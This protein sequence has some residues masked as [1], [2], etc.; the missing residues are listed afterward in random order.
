MTFRATDQKEKL[1]AAIKRFTYG[2]DPADRPAATEYLRRAAKRHGPVISSY[3]L[4]HPFIVGRLLKH[5]LRE[6][7]IH[8]TP[9]RESGWLGL[10]HTVFFQRAFITC[11]YTDGEEVIESA[12]CASEGLFRLGLSIRAERVEGVNI[13]ND[14][15]T[16]ILVTAP[17]LDTG[18][19][20]LI[21]QKPALAG[22]LRVLTAS[23]DMIGGE[24]A[25][26]WENVKEFFLGEPCGAR[27]SLFVN[28]KT[29]ATMRRLLSELNKSG[30]FGDEI[31]P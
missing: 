22:A 21:A 20:G 11:P 1:D 6:T 16:P 9:S 5:G 25:E 23:V 7:Y 14:K 31:A 4:W 10:D 19:D 28:E 24:V 27:S 8:R 15:V 18:E 26:P 13:Y 2:L 29:G 12:K 30:V 17:L 3:P